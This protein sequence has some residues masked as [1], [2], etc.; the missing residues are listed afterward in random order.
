MKRTKVISALSAVA[1]A[2]IAGAIA[3]PAQA[4][5]LETVR[6]LSPDETLPEGDGW[7]SQ[8]GGVTGGSGGQLINVYNWDELK[9]AIQVSGT[10]SAPREVLLHGTIRAFG[11]DDEQ[12]QLPTCADFANQVTIA[13]TDRRFS[14][15]E[16]IATY[17]PAVW[18]RTPPTGPVEDARQAAAALQ[19]AQVRVRVRSNVTIFGLGPNSRLVGAHLNVQGPNA[20]TQAHNVIIRNF[21]SSDAYDCFPEWDPTDGALGNWNSLYDN[22]SVHSTSN[23]WVDHMRLNDGEH[24]PQSLPE[25]FGRHYEVHDGLLDVTHSS[26]YVTASYN[27][28][29]HHDKTSLV[30]SSDNR[31][32]EDAGKLKVT[33]HHN[34]WNEVGQRTPRV[35]FGD[36]DVYNN[37]YRLPAEEDYEYSLGVGF[38]SSIIAEKNAFDLSPGITAD[39]I[40]RAY[41]GTRI[42][43]DD[44]DVDGEPVDILAAYNAANPGSPLADSA[45]WSNPPRAGEVLPPNEVRDVVTT[46]AGPKRWPLLGS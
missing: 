23:V 41:N 10:G 3:V 46:E 28:L 2:A 40:I 5:T 29:E 15:E 7:G 12:S 27:I 24:P 33:W 30:G 34:W 45:R 19:T 38:E 36:V 1:L 11:F 8:N 43:V 6:A 39:Q 37:Y 26:D 32:V 14:M 44:N 31:V 16:Y 35:R 17:D 25:V 18:G 22:I 4:D 20:S 42:K 13:G 9:A 21:E